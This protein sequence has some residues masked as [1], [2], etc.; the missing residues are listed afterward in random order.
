MLSQKMFFLIIVF[1]A[2]GTSTSVLDEDDYDLMY[3]N[4]DNEIEGVI[5][6]AEESKWIQTIFL[7]SIF[8]ENQRK[9][10]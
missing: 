2:F 4:F 3:E 6:P 10:I 1:C 8:Y 5:P 9:H 7:D